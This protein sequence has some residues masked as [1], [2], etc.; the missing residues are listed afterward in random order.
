MLPTQP[1]VKLGW[2]ATSA[3]VKWLL[4]VP[5]PWPTETATNGADEPMATSAELLQLQQL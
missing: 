2:T 5:T 3:P 1:Q 4:P